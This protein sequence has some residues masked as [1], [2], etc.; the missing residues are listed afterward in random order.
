MQEIIVQI[1]SIP[2]ST[3]K[4]TLD[5]LKDYVEGDENLN[6]LI[7]EYKDEL[8]KKDIETWVVDRNMITTEDGYKIALY[9]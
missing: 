2:L 6:K 9:E 7:L 4:E 1:I 8:A 5:K 3:E